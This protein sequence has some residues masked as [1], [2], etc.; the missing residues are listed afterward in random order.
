MASGDFRVSRH[1]YI[2]DTGGVDNPHELAYIRKVFSWDATKAER[3]Y[4]KHGV[5]FEE[6]ASV[7]FDSKA[8]D[9]EDREHLEEEQRW[10]RLGFSWRARLI[11]AFTP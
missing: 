10:K 1:S 5:S 8:L 9:W 2:W 11:L 6:A 7:F 3:N 4:E